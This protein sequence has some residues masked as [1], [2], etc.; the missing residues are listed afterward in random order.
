MTEERADEASHATGFEGYL[1]RIGE[2]SEVWMDVLELLTALIMIL[3]FTIGVFDLTL[4]VYQL[5]ANGTYTDPNAVIKIIDTAL[6]LLIIVEIYRTV[7]AYV[8]ELPIL[9]IVIKVGIIAMTRKIISF[10]TGKYASKSDALIAAVAYGLL[11]LVL[12]G[13]FYAVYRSQQEAD[14]D[15]FDS[16]EVNG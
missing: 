7:I 12:V 14:F 13:T 9:P 2:H 10:R 4:K 16:E 1:R 6:L 8:E 11:L 3:L 15:I 5:I